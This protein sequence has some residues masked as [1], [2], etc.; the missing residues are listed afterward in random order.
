MQFAV[1]P[2]IIILGLSISPGMQFA[3]RPLIIILEI[4]IWIW[5]WICF[6]VGTALKE[7]IFYVPSGI[8][9][10]EVATYE[11]YVGPVD[12]L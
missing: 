8:D 10:V 12:G 1:R 3:A 5:I 6:S 11:S 7:G 2:L 9:A 4:W